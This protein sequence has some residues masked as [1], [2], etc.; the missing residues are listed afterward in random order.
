VTVENQ[1]ASVAIYARVSTVDQH[2]ELQLRELRDYCKRRKW[3]VHKEYVDTI[4]GKLAAR[5]A[6]DKLLN[7]AREHRIDCVCVWKI[8]RFG[9]SVKNF[10]EHVSR[11]DGLGVRFLSMTQNIDTDRSDPM[12]RLLMHILAAFAEFEREMIVERVKSGLAAAKARGIRLGRPRVIVDKGKIK[13]MHKR[14]ASLREIAKKAG[15]SYMT[16]ARILAA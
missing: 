10:T 11:L 6:L 12:S 4:T 13:A 9:R 3:K 5:P 15:C 7:D 2:C 14:G 16:V 8:D 1:P